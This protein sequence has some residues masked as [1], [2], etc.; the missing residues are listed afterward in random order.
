MSYYQWAINR[1]SSQHHQK[2]NRENRKCVSRIINHAQTEQ[3]QLS[4][5]PKVQK[6]LNER[7]PEVNLTDVKLYLVAREAL[8]YQSANIGGC[9][10]K[11]MRIIFI[12][13]NMR[14]SPQKRDKFEK[15]MRQHSRAKLLREDVLVHEYIH[16]VSDKIGRAC[17]KHQHM[18]EEF[19]YTNCIDF[20]RERGMSDDDIVKNNFLPFCVNDVLSSRNNM[21]QIF[22]ELDISMA[23]LVDLTEQE[24]KQLFNDHAEELVSKIV[25]KATGKATKMIEL[26]NKFG[27]D[28]YKVSANKPVGNASALRFSSLELE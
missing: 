4:N 5:Y 9:Y 8:D 22:S 24:Y 13:N 21:I 12:K 26:Y 14:S 16:A 15:I 28:M 1:K 20:Y 17:N 25:K 18:E 19:V 6:Y 10:I 11:N 7:F 2:A 23:D 27:R 3:K